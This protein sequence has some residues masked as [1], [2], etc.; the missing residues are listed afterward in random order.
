MDSLLDTRGL[1][2]LAAGQSGAAVVDFK[3]SIFE[4]ESAE[5][6]FHLAVAYSRIGAIKDAKES[7][8]IAE[9]LGLFE[10]DLHPK[11]RIMLK[12]LRKLLATEGA[13]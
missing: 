6:Q 10:E 8:A 12:T 5:N 4:K 3:S 7:L 9:K 2:S 11:E 1:V 13:N